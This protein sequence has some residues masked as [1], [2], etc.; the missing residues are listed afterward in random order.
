MTQEDTLPVEM[1]PKTG[2]EDL[3]SEIVLT[4]AKK[5]GEHVTCRRITRNHYRCNW[6]KPDNVGA[7]G[8]PAGVSLLFITNRICKSRFL[9]VTKD[10]GGLQIS[11]V[12]P[13][14][15]GLDGDPEAT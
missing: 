2:D 3:S 14:D 4:V 7:I 9:H 6:W 10:T 8:K 11:E 12:S 15:A 13:G 1:R 5:S